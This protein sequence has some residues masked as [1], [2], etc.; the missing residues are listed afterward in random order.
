MFVRDSDEFLEVLVDREVL[1]VRFIGDRY[2]VF[3]SDEEILKATHAIR[4]TGGK[5][6]KVQKFT[7]PGY[8]D[9]RNFVFIR[10]NSCKVR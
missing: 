5:Y 4:V 1:D 3:D 8:S 7:L 2:R 6:E 9:E 10:S